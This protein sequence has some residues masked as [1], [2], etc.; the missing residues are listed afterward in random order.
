MIF[1]YIKHKIFLMCNTFF[2][3]I[4]RHYCPSL[5]FRAQHIYTGADKIA[6]YED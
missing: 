1:F 4:Y 2:F 3:S 5:Q 6:M